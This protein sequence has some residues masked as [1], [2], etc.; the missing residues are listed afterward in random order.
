MEFPLYQPVSKRIISRQAIASLILLLPC[1]S[2]AAEIPASTFLTKTVGNGLYELS[3]DGHKQRLFAASSPSFD[4]E[5]ARGVVYQ[6]N[7]ATLTTEAEIK[8]SRLAFATALDE[9]NQRLYIG[10]TLDGSVTVIDT[11]TGK[12]LSIIQLSES[13]QGDRFKPTREMV[14]DRKNHRLYVSSSA[15][16]GVLWVIDTATGEKIN[17]IEGLGNSVTGIALDLTRNS[18]YLVNG[19]GE[20][21]TLDAKNYKIKKRLTVEPDKTHFLLNISLDEKKGRAFITDPDVA[22]VLVVDVTSGK[23]VHRIDVINSLAILFNPLRNEI[24]ISHRNA[25]RISIV[26]SETYRVKAAVT[27]ALLP[28]S[29]AVSADGNSLYA[30]VKQP[31]EEMSTRQDDILNI[32]L[33]AIGKEEK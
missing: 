14:F 19:S 30:S 3:F 24:Y 26:D 6:L 21:I 25:K 1:Y 9:E 27:T 13:R 15:E 20:M 33:T 23:I 10:N 4:R 16:K 31:K 29:L 32:D 17:T 7:A 12:E 18:I 28:N 8:I 5:K 2:Y 11:E 22:G